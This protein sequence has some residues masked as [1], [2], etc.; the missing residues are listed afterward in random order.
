MADTYKGY[1]EHIVYHNE[2]NGYTVF[3]IT[4]D[5]D[6]EEIT[7]VGN[8]PVINEG[9]KVSVEGS[10]IDHR[11]YGPQL[12]VNKIQ[13]LKP[14]GVEAIEKYLASGAIKGIG[15]V[16][17]KRIVEKFGGDTFD[18]IENEPERLAEIKGVSMNMA[19]RFSEQFDA[20]RERR[21]AMIF[22]QQYGISNQLAVKIYTEYKSD[23]FNIVNTNPY[24]LA[25][26]VKGVGFRIADE[27]G[28]KVGI[29]VD[30]PYRI[31]CAITYV[32]AQAGSFGHIY[33]PENE[34]A[35]EVSRLIG[36]DDLFISE[37]L[38]ELV[39]E[40]EIIKKEEENEVR[41][42]GSYMYY[43]ELNCAR[44][45]L[46]LNNKLGISEKNIDRKIEEIQNKKDIELAA[47]QREAVAAALRNGVVIITGGPGTGKT[48]TI[49]AIISAFESE[50]MEMLLAAPTGRAA[51]RMSETTGYPAQTIHRLLELSGGVE[52]DDNSGMNFERNESYPL[53]TDVII[54][55]E[56]SMVDLPL[57][58]ALLKAIVVGTKLIM[59]GDVNQLPSV[60]PGNVLKDIIDSGSFEVVRLNQVFRQARDSDIV[61]NAHLIN[62]G[63][64][65][66]LNN[67]ST[68]FFMLQR[69]NP[70][71]I[72]EV[73]LYL[74][75]KKMPD[76]VDAGILDIQVLCPMRKGELGVENMNVLLQRY[77][78]PKD[79]HKQEMVFRETIFREGDKVM[80]IKNNYQIVWERRGY[81][82]VVLEEGTGVF[83]GD[84]GIIRRIDATANEITVE[85]EDNKYITYPHSS[86]EELELAYA[87]TV[88][89]SQGSEYPAVIL[90]LLGGTSLLMH[91]N[92]LYTAVTRAKKCVTIVGSV[93]TVNNMIK[94]ER[95]QKRYTSL[96]RRIVEMDKL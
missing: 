80:Q 93:D 71:N 62:A 33:L 10:F 74:I 67:S 46:D 2:A 35:G 96:K 43:M 94:N 12:K 11:Q 20:K 89:K 18:I 52:D 60:G 34:L 27:I 23:L 82:G 32:M 45:L 91:R 90:P 4:N 5:D 83:N 44:M 57:L 38:E 65:I 81:N 6:R 22:L 30:S 95:E 63:K 15:M 19:M 61:M 14:D 42:Y 29:A 17:A 87:I 36:V 58:N 48:T 24:K 73:C 86:L 79:V 84:C 25:K 53:E 28:K 77:I 51:K 21:D 1:V 69:D 68:D 54:I 66:K 31:K 50:G 16:M 39:Y 85:F 49:D 78:N 59:V 41:Y 9:E 70:K 47:M 64:E 26:D 8:C 56:M 75:M 55:D 7:C 92:L 3:T 88:H 13:V 76:Y 72:I 40:K 37:A